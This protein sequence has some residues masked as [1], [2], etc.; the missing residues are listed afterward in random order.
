MK[1]LRIFKILTC[2]SLTPFFL[3]KL[4]IDEGDRERERNIDLLVYLLILSLVDCCVC[5]DW[6]SNLQP[7]H[8]GTTL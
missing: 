5:S 2:L 6:R 4:L 8:I 3:K 7:C 1:I